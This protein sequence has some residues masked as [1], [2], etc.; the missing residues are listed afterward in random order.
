VHVTEELVERATQ[1]DSRHCMIAEAIQQQRPEWKQILVDLQTI[2][3]T[4]PRTSKRYVALTPE[5]AGSALVA[6]DRGERIAPFS[7]S[8]EPIQVTEMKRHV[9][10]DG[11][12]STVPRTRTRKPRMR[13]DGRLDVVEG[14]KPLPA[15]HLRGGGNVAENAAASELPPES[16]SN[17]VKSSRRYRRYGLRLLRD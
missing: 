8:L 10:A 5:V 13:S 7:F 16:A 4:N 17:A 15:G 2:R 9:N 14:G 6:F 12:T 11:S 1:R 3:W